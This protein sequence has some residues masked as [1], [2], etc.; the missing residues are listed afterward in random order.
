MI[1]NLLACFNHTGMMN[2]YI[3]IIIICINL[4]TITDNKPFSIISVPLLV[5]LVIF[6]IYVINIYPGDMD[7]C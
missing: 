1:L 3:F 2:F 4:I 6:I 5:L 7:A